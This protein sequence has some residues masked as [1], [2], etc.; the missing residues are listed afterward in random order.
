MGLLD[1]MD[2]LDPFK[3]DFRLGFE[4]ET[5]LV[6]YL[7]RD[8]DRGSVTLL[9]LLDLSAVFDTINHS[10]LLEFLSDLGLSGIVFDWFNSFLLG[11]SYL[12]STQSASKLVSRLN[13]KL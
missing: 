6:D 5:T 12:L 1:E 4:M 11:M 10:P 13:S 8:L 7:R 3:A 2:Y 9:V